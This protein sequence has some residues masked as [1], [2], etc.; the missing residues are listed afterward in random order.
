MPY[1]EIWVDACDVCPPCEEC[2]D[3]EE[4]EDDAILEIMREWYFVK[5]RGDYERFERFLASQNESAW[6]LI[7]YGPRSGGPVASEQKLASH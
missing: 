2:K 1:I 6:R 5:D 4:R 7:V 3:R